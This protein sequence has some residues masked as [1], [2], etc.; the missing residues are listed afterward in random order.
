MLTSAEIWNKQH[1]SHI[2]KWRNS[3]LLTVAECTCI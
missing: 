2:T 1:T 3:D